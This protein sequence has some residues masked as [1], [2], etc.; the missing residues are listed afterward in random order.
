MAP[1]P[2]DK[3]WITTECLLRLFDRGRNGGA[4]LLALAIVRSSVPRAVFSST[5]FQA[6]VLPRWEWRLRVPICQGSQLGQDKKMPISLESLCERLRPESTTL[7]LGAGSSMPSGAPSGKALAEGLWRDVASIEPQSDELIETTSILERRYSRKSVVDAILKKLQPLKPTGGLLGLPAFAW[8][9]VF[10]TNFDEL[11]ELAYKRAKVPFTRIRSN[12]DLPQASSEEGTP[13]YKIHGCVTQDRALGHKAS[14]L[15]TEQDYEDFKRYRQSLFSTLETHLLSG[16]VLILGQSLSDR[17][18]TDLIREVLRAKDE[19]APGQ[20]YVLIYTEDDLRAPLFEDRGARVAFGGLDEFVHVMASGASSA[21]KHRAV[22]GAA[23]PLELVSIV[24]NV[25]EARL[26][27][28]SVVKM[29]NGSAASYSDIRANATFERT[30]VS[31]EVEAIASGALP[32]L[33]LIGAAGVGKTTTARILLY[34]LYEKGFL[35]VEHRNDF[36]FSAKPWIHFEETLRADGKRAVLLLDECTRHLRQVNLLLEALAKIED[37]ALKIVLTANAAQWEPRLKSPVVFSH[38]KILELSRL[39]NPDLHSLINLLESNKNI[40]DL[41][42]KDFKTLIR[43]DQFARLRERCGADMFVCLKN[44]FAND[45]LD[46]ILLTEFAELDDSSQEFYRY[47]AAL[48]SVGMRVHRQLV[49][50]MLNVRADSVASALSRLTGIVDEFDIDARQGIYGWATRHLVIARKIAEFKFSS[51]EELQSLFERIIEN[52]NPFIQIELQ[53]VRDICDRDFGIGRLGEASVRKALYRKLIDA[54][55]GERIPWHRLIRELLLEGNFEEASY[56]IRDAKA[57]VGADG[58]IDRFSVRL[59]VARAENLSG[60]TE[61]DRTALLRQAY[62]LAT[63]N[64]GRHKFDKYSYY[65]LC[66]VATK[67]VEK[68]ESPYILEEALDRARAAAEVILDPD[69]DQ[70]LNRYEA[71]FARLR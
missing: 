3:A 11:V 45:S 52:I 47:V 59:L 1:S 42:Q 50:R 44:I 6:P 16:D 58:P 14:L 41:V 26:H 18:L 15:L 23:I 63:K 34:R 5:Y 38:G 57:S 46:K 25:D 19:G 9:A 43:K 51:L 69:L 66:D 33:S 24:D 20:I 65:V 68:G 30:H 67:L 56:A 48:E 10:T 27:E 28:P 71:T 36:P 17:H 54:A 60:I 12:Y 7:L 32:L 55:P 2:V 21:S 4:R 70:K 29:F 39:E 64:V 8:R 31:R 35:A 40:S 61:A 49:M 37:A 62:E 53:S 13:I 22:E